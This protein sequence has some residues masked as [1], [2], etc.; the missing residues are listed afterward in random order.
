MPV[1]IDAW[2]GGGTDLTPTF[3]YPEDA[4]HFHRTLKGIADRHHPSFYPRFKTWCA[5]LEA[6]RRI[7]ARNTRGSAGSVD[8]KQA[9]SM[10]E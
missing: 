6:A 9:T 5:L 2:L 4:V 8:M 10:G 3:P 1:K 7:P